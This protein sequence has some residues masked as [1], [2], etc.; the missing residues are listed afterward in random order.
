MS[1]AR[2][3][4]PN[5]KQTSFETRGGLNLVAGAHSV[6]PGEAIQ[7]I[8]Y[9]LDVDGY[10]RRIRGYE[11]FDGQDRPSEYLPIGD[12]D[13]DAYTVDLQAGVAARRALILPVPGEGRIL[14]VVQ[15]KGV[16]YAWRNDT[17]GASAKMWE[18]TSSG[19]SEVVTGFTLNPD[20]EYEFDIANMDGAG[21]Q[22]IRL[23]GCNG[24]DK[25]FIYDGTTF[26]QIT[27]GSPSFA[28]LVKVFKNHL[29]LAHTN[30]SLQHSEIGLPESWGAGAAELG[31]S[32]EITNLSIPPGGAMVVE[33]KNRVDVLYGTSK[34]NW[35]LKEFS[36]KI[37]GKARTAQIIGDVIS[38]DDV[39]ITQLK[40]V[41]SFGD[42]QSSSISAKIQPIIDIKRNIVASSSVL[43]NKNQ[44]RVYF[45]DGT[46]ITSTF[47]FNKTLGFSTLDFGTTVVRTIYSSEDSNGDDRTYF[48]SDDGYIYEMD[49]GTSFDGEEIEYV[50]RLSY[51][52]IGSSEHY[53]R[54]VKAT[55][56]I[57]VEDQTTI[58]IV[59]DFNY[60]SDDLP[61]QGAT[62]FNL[63]GNGG[64]YGSAVFGKARFGTPYLSE[65]HIPLDATALNVGFL[66]QSSQQ[67]DAPHTIKSVTLHYYYRRR[68]R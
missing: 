8:N 16:V 35:E 49:V 10:Y 44:Y 28:H 19:W 4:T 43:K 32:D 46:A 13:D 53:K 31:I 37:G 24:V 2:F 30:G 26:T 39:G 51:T 56:F 41:Q 21:S 36:G 23:Y 9:E 68:N 64:Y 12:F 38:L 60:A 7:L 29:F 67:W 27:T 6:A 33:S 54:M 55:A 11:R 48:G 62:E 45:T 40:R 58:N 47:K 25:E 57:D 42:F 34:A 1:P 65:A 3:H 66:F 20:G 17:G 22:G 50:C 59:P 14:G 15:Y 63:I 61:M 52:N 18:S 5:I